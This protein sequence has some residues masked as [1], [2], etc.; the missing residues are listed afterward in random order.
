MS[1]NPLL[2]IC[3]PTFNSSGLLAIMLEA[4]LPQTEKQ[5]AFIEVIV[6]DNA[7]EDNS[8]E[9]VEKFSQVFTLKYSVNKTNLGP[10]KNIIKCACE[11][12]TGEFVWVLGS[13]NLTTPGSIDHLIRTLDKCRHLNILYANFNCAKYPEHWPET[14][15]G[16]FTG[17]IHYTANPELE[18]RE[19]EHWQEL[20]RPGS[21]LCTQLYAHIIKRNIWVEY[22]KNKSLGEPYTDARTTYPH[23]AMIAET[24]FNQPS[25]YIGKPLITIFNG[26]QTWGDLT[27]RL[28]VYFLGLP[29]LIDLYIKN[30]LPALIRIDAQR[31]NQQVA[32]P[33][34]TGYFREKASEVD[35]LGRKLII[36]NITRFYLLKTIWKGYQEARTH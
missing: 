25:Y 14:A 5:G 9:V 11:L 28:K 29:D 15:K 19:L 32:K 30:G 20:V 35:Y 6:S 26:A 4:L 13:H 2:S 23:S 12:A 24:L 16:G 8:R 10:V 1:V 22:W 17:E 7:S 34:I 36:K 27:T 31:W 33:M 3:I 18:N 21:A